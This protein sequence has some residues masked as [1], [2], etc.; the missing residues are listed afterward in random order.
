MWNDQL[1]CVYGHDGEGG[2]LPNV[3]Q[4]YNAGYMA[5]ERDNNPS[6]IKTIQNG[7]MDSWIHVKCGYTEITVYACVQAIDRT[8]VLHIAY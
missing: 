1:K 4:K 2:K 6:P 8:Q 5:S 3:W 7:L